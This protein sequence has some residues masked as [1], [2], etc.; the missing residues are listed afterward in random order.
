MTAIQSTTTTDEERSALATLAAALRPFRELSPGTSP[1]P[2]SLLL[3]FLLI[4][5]R[6]NS[7][8]I[9]LAKDAN[10]TQGAISRQLAD[11]SDVNRYGGTGFGLVEQRVEIHDRRYTRT[12]LTEKGRAIVRRMASEMQ[13]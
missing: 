8:V 2:L 9:D 7:T 3:T 11:L 5:G 10:M 6:E 4:A 1:I 12:R 13:G